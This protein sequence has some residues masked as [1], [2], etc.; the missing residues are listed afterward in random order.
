MLFVTAGKKLAIASTVNSA[1]V[2]QPTTGHKSSTTD[3]ADEKTP[4]PEDAVNAAACSVIN[5]LADKVPHVSVHPDSSVSSGGHHDKL[6]E[7]LSLGQHDKVEDATPHKKTRSKGNKANS[8]L[9]KR[10]LKFG[11]C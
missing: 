9:W 5:G 3:A 1:K 8:R 6:E 11:P 10:L 4:P 7:N 2:K